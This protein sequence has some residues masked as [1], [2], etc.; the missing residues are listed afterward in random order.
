MSRSQDTQLAAFKFLLG[1]YRAE[2]LARMAARFPNR[3]RTSL[4]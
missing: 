3:K 1:E 4:V 2:R